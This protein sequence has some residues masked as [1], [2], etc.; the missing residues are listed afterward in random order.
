MTRFEKNL[1]ERFQGMFIQGRDYATHMYEGHEVRV[2]R[3]AEPTDIM[4]TNLKFDRQKK[5]LTRFFVMMVTL[6]MILLSLGII[7]L[8]NW[9]QVID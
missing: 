3:A 2:R 6:L 4:W 8:V 5:I 7:I 1:L 9:W